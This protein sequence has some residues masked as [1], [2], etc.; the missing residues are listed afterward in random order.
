MKNQ[1]LILILSAGML[2]CNNS[3]YSKKQQLEKAGVL[4]V[5]E[6]HMIEQTAGMNGKMQGSFFLGSGDVSGQVNSERQLQFFWGRTKNE[7]ICT[8]LPY[9]AFQFIIDSTVIVP[10]VEFV[11]SKNYLSSPGTP[12]SEV[13]NYNPNNWL[14]QDLFKSGYLDK[15]VVRISHVDLEKEIYLPK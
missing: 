4:G 9:S 14:T 10:T 1:F 12:P 7:V 11:Y 13:T 6:L 2:S 8:T 5:Y 15:A 3:F